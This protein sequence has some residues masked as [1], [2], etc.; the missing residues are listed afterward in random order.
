MVVGAINPLISPGT[1]P[2]PANFPIFCP[3]TCAVEPFAPRKEAKG[4]S[5]GLGDYWGA[6]DS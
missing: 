1:L 4:P 2:V 3:Q 5:D 6:L